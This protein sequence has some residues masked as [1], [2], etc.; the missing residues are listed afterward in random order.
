M[1]PAVWA[2]WRVGGESVPPRRHSHYA[3]VSE[4]CWNIFTPTLTPDIRSD[5]CG[6]RCGERCGAGCCM[7]KCS[8]WVGMCNAR[9]WARQISCPLL[10]HNNQ[11][12]KY[13]GII[14]VHTPDVRSLFINAGSLHVDA[15][16]W[17]PRVTYGPMGGEDYLEPGCASPRGVSGG[18]YRAVKLVTRYMVMVC[19]KQC[20][21]PSVNPR[22]PATSH[23]QPATNW[24]A[25]PPQLTGSFIQS[26]NHSPPQLW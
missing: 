17:E 14:L 9:C 21:E 12:T 13:S 19:C 16:Q 8:G 25:C 22:Q 7:R 24:S 26:W 11:N 5:I 6:V 2:V 23:H 4:V 3:N 18:D 15:D 1:I 10:P 20:G